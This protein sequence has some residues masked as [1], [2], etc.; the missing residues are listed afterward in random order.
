[1]Q[2]Q[3]ISPQQSGLIPYLKYFKRSFYLAGGT[4]VAL[5]IGHRRSIVFDLFSHFDLNKSRIKA[6]LR[7]IPFE[8]NVLQSS[9]QK[10][11]HFPFIFFIY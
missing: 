9:H 2:R 4:A 1:M 8:Q 6:K 11:F 10:Y 7:T 5:H 3:I